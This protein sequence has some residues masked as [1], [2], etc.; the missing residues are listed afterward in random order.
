MTGLWRCGDHEFA[1]DR[2][3]VMGI[4]NV[5]PD[6]FSNGGV[7]LDPDVAIATAH[8]MVASGA[9][10]V[11]VGGESTRPGSG[12][13]DPAEEL[14]RVLP[15]VRALAADGLV[16]S[17][18]TRHA[19]VAAAA[20]EAGAAIINDISGFEDPAMVAVA[21]AC[22]AGLVV[23]HMQ[24]DPR[25]M[26]A[27]PHYHDVVAE[28]TGYLAA[29]AAALEVEGVAHDRIC[30]DPGIGFGKTTAHNLELLRRL[31]VLVALGYP[32]LVGASRKRFVGEITGVTTPADRLAG[33][34]AVALESVA[35]GAAIV[36][37]H[38]AAET[39]QA[40]A[41]AAAIRGGAAAR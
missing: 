37:V 15:V 23:M 9:D 33:S 35:R 32:V 24:G 8:A 20:M 22:G 38:D 30:L 18:D 13:V 2:A 6:S 41:M 16:V 14:S 5:T 26:Q 29:Q 21:R 36:R 12:E 40:L 34:I 3:L 39:A 4:I 28:V 17:V 25:T 19:K 11:D 27:E 1:L 7:H 31:D 10:I